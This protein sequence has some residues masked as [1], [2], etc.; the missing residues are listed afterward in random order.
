MKQNVYLTHMFPDYEPPEE[1]TEAL[2]QAAIVA[3]D[4]DPDAKRVEVAL[5]SENYIPQRLLF[6][7]AHCSPSRVGAA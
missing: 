2:S 7:G 3:A 6:P 4:I 1:L 5:H